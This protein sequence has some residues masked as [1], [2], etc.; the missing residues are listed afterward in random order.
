MELRVLKYFVKIAEEENM[1]K[2]AQKLHVSQPALSKQ[3]KELETEVGHVLFIR[4][5]QRMILTEK[6]MLLKK[7]AENILSMVDKTLEEINNDELLMGNI[8]IG[9]GPTDNLNQIMKII[10]DF[11]INYP[12][13]K[14]HIKSGDKYSLLEGIENGLLDFGIF[15]REYDKRYYE[16]IKL[17]LQNELGLW[18]HKDHFLANK[19]VIDTIELKDIPLVVANQAIKDGEVP[20]FIAD[21]Q[22]IG[23]YDLIENARMIVKHNLASALVINKED[24]DS[25][26]KF[27][28]IKDM[29][30][31][32]WYIIWK[33]ENK[34]K[35]Q[36]R[37]ITYLKK[38]LG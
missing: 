30:R 14:F 26:L 33:K 27:I 11:R 15:I 13:V 38:R 1:T 5:K 3:I 20:S 9:T 7:R 37:F 19:K 32:H 4:S 2:A 16:G 23:T 22:I 31:Y 12:M 17:N 18:V 21:N 35:I 6:G 34:T 24:Y 28:H 29:P 36:E 25:D 10:K 8:Y